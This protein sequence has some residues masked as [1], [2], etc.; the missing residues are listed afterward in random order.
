MVLA[1][2]NKDMNVVSTLLAKAVLLG[3][4]GLFSPNKTND[5]YGVGSPD[6]KTITMG[7]EHD[8]LRVDESDLDG[9][10]EPLIRNIIQHDFKRM[11]WRDTVPLEST[12][13]TAPT[14]T[15]AVD[16]NGTITTVTP[17]GGSGYSG[18]VP[19]LIAVPAVGSYGHGAVLLP[20]M[21]GGTVSAVTVQSGGVDYT[22]SAVIVTNAGFSEG[23]LY[24][25]PIFHP[26]KIKGIGVIYKN[27]VASA[28]NLAKNAGKDPAKAMLNLTGDSI[29]GEIAN[30]ATQIDR[31]MI[32]GSPASEAD[33]MWTQQYGLL[34]AIDDGGT[35]AVYA[36]VD[37]TLSDGSTHWWRGI[38]DPGTKNWGIDDFVDDANL[39][40][41]LSERSGGVDL[42]LVHP[43]ML[44]KWKKQ[45]VAQLV[46]ANTD[47]KLRE[48][49][50]FGFSS[51]VLK[52]GN[53]YVIAH[54]G[55]PVKTGLALNTAS[56]LFRFYNGKKFSPSQLWDL[57]GQSAGKEAHKFHVETNWLWAII[58]NMN[59]KYTALS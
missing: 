13:G 44:M 52:Y 8:T 10:Y 18:S 1:L 33:K 35:Q 46:N 22:T 37:R 28:I 4:L 23:E 34:A 40:K 3:A 15:V 16:A 29:I 56:M 26:S 30:G 31:D 5:V 42:G 49:A 32:N 24:A 14:W 11:A 25:R 39:E 12:A 19:T 55:M 9:A 27:D 21:S 20:T 53:T 43:K 54:P 47:D 51:E 48:M 45:G 57:E 6:L 50:E 17:S 7:Y 58:P 38:V 2:R 41:G 59:A 36:G